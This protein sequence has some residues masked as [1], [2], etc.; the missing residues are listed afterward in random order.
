MST[1][2]ERSPWHRERLREVESQA[3][4]E[5][6]VESLPVMTK[7]DLMDNFDEIVTDRR[8]TMELCEAHLAGSSRDPYLLGEYSVVASG[9]S[10]GR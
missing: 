6:D 5:A 2:R 8:V 3:L 1:A 10:S 9:G 7:A 4:T